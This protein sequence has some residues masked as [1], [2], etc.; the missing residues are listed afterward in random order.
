MAANNDTDVE[1]ATTNAENK[2]KTASVYG[3]EGAV[4]A[5]L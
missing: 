2:S 3:S 5:K 1:L 4:A